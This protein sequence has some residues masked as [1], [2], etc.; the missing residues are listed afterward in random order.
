MWITQVR[1]AFA[2]GVS[3][4]TVRENRISGQGSNLVMAPTIATLLLAA[5]AATALAA[6]VAE[7]DPMSSRECMAAREELEQ[8]IS[9]PADRRARSE[10]IARAR[11]QA[12]LA[13]L[14]PSS[15]SRERS[16]APQPPQAVPAPVIGVRPAPAPPAAALAV[17]QPP[18]AIP[19]PAVITACDPA[20]CWDS[21]GRRLNNMGPL[22][23]GPRGLCT[24]HGGVLNC[25]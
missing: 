7:A 6:T 14:G 20:G 17:P 4:E 18:L 25:P 13:C 12:A 10:R 19:R 11:R 21:E 8:A 23:M 22:L 24:M 9:E 15:G 1:Q 16:G 5:G 2:A 3:D